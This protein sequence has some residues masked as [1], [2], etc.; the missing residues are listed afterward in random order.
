MKKVSREMKT[1]REEEERKG[2]ER[3]WVESSKNAS[4]KCIQTLHGSQ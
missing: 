3:V 1:A 2:E 4:D